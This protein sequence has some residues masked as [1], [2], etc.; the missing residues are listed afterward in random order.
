[1]RDFG[2]MKL[3]E[4]VMLARVM[5]QKYGVNV[6]ISQDRKTASCSSK[7]SSLV[8]GQREFTISLPFLKDKGKFDKMIRGYLDH[9]IGHVQYTDFNIGEELA[10]RQPEY[11]D[12]YFRQI[13]NIF[14]DVYIE[15]RMS[16]A[17]PGSKINLQWMTRN[18]FTPA[19]AFDSVKEIVD[20]WK[21]GIVGIRETV[22]DFV[23]VYCLFK[24]RAMLDNRLE[25]SHK[26]L[27]SVRGAL[28]KL[29]S[30]IEATLDKVDDTLR[31]PADSSDETCAL[32]GQIWY[33][34]HDMK[35][36]Q[37]PHAPQ[38]G[39]FGQGNNGGQQNGQSGDS[40]S[41]DVPGSNG[42][43][44][45][46][47][48]T[49]QEKV[50]ATQEMMIAVVEASDGAFEKN[51]NGSIK[52]R[53]Q[54]PLQTEVATALS[55]M[56]ADG[57]DGAEQETVGNGDSFIGVCSALRALK[58]LSDVEFPH[59]CGK[60]LH[61]DSMNRIALLR[62]GFMR[63]IP[64]LLQSVQFTPSRVGYTGRMSG[65]DLHKVG[66]GNGRIFQKKAERREQRV[67]VAILLDA[68]G[69]MAGD[70]LDAQ[71]TLYAMLGMLKI[72]PRVRSYAAIF[73]SKKYVVL[74]RFSDKRI[75]NYRKVIAHGNTPTAGAV[76]KVLPELSTSIDV[77][78]LLFVIT[79]GEPDSPPAFEQ[80]MKIAHSQGVEV[81]GIGLRGGMPHM[82][83]QFGKD[84]VATATDIRDLP[85]KL[86]ALM[87]NALARAVA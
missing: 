38:Q 6:Q 45:Q 35:L 7:P 71:I 17:F 49:H 73:S 51:K 11:F 78:R 50:N 53:K 66:I 65:R 20:G 10:R 25:H 87:K 47:P 75:N 59:S 54:V 26:L 76:L 29:D 43:N 30:G 46:Q 1:M 2:K 27:D 33:A 67:D 24:R 16:A 8:A 69:S 62:S 80:A 23:T 64:G 82:D 32:A 19:M 44:S 60:P 12:A 83:A 18:I 70:M 63:T 68:S 55:E 34:L 41:Q 40:D 74:S 84:N 21:D 57:R 48:G 61:Q 77:R 81:Y 4:L 86:A 52:H 22:Y 36:K 15:S 72:L 58:A 79:D 42:S 9:K 39:K 31:Q 28:T 37:K 3:T 14:E 13:W 56:I 5:S 85:L